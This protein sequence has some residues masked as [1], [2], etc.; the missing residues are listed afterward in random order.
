MEAEENSSQHRSWDAFL[1]LPPFLVLF[2]QIPSLR[3]A[4]AYIQGRSFFLSS[5]SLRTSSQAHPGVCFTNLIRASQSDE[6]D[7]TQAEAH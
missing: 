1:S 2:H 3:D 5:P 4:V 7:P 6:K